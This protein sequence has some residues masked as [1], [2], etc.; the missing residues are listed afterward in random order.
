MESRNALLPFTV[1]E[2]EFALGFVGVGATAAT[3][4]GA[5]G[6][7]VVAGGAGALV[8]L[9]LA[10]VFAYASRSRIVDVRLDGALHGRGY[11]RA[12][13]RA[14][15]SL[16]VMHI[17]DDAP[18]EELLGLYR[19]LLDRG[20]EIRRLIF[21][22]PDHNPEGIRW[23]LESG[24]HDRLRQRYVST[25]PG[26]LLTLGFAVVDESAVLVAVPGF[27]PTDTEPYS[28]RIVLRHLAELRNPAV[29][30]AFLEIYESAWRR[31]HPLE[32]PRSS[33]R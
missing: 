4:L 27:D 28:E 11:V 16:L 17:D 12:F 13:R 31:A 1:R 6:P 8:G 3:L 26:A 7:L 23:V 10:S 29:T 24:W 25:E 5:P 14:R 33:P 30:R 2:L 18:N 15:K 19:V 22:R 32:L 21:V 9:Y 20:V